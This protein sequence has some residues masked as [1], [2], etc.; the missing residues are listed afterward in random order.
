MH[1]YAG[2]TRILIC[3]P[4]CI[5]RKPRNQQQEPKE[6][7]LRTNHRI[8]ARRVLVIGDRGERV[9]EFLTPDAVKLAQE[10]GM[11][12]IEVAP[13][14][15]PPVCKLGDYGRLMYEK[16]KKDSKARKK[17]SIVNV[18]EVKLRPKTDI[19]DYE[20]KLKH[21]RKFLESGDKL[22]VTI[23]FRG[24]EMAHQNIGRDLCLRLFE[25]MRDL[26]TIE[27]QPRMDGRQM[28]MILAPLKSKS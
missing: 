4:G 16:K 14:A 26:S 7:G 13:N 6:S 5:L 9:G 28:C 2:Q 20:V 3:I 12:L 23:R 18:K 25:Q 11:D 19:H 22:K 1:F 8:R 17:Q 27:S 21:G 10:R 15:N 24:R